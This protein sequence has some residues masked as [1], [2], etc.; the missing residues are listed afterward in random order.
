VGLCGSLREPSLDLFSIVLR[1]VILDILVHPGSYC[2]AASPCVIA[3]IVFCGL[4]FL[5][6]DYSFSV[7]SCFMG[8]SLDIPFATGCLSSCVRTSSCSCLS[9]VL[10]IHLLSPVLL[11]AFFFCVCWTSLLSFL[12]C[13]EDVDL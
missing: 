6:F 8:V 12:R 13:P 2:L 10:S 9:R 3:T 7:V 11:L 5:R 4:H 1:S